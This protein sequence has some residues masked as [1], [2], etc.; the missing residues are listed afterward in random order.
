MKKIAIC[1]FLSSMLSLVSCDDFLTLEPETSLSPESYFKTAAELELWTNGFYSI[2]GD[3]EDEVRLCADDH[4]CTTLNSVQKGTRT[5]ATE[6]WSSSWDELRDINYFLEHVDNCTDEE[7]KN[8]FMGVAYFFRALFYFEKVR[9]YG[10]VPY[11]D[12]VISNTD[13]NALKKPRDSR[14]VVMKRVMDDFDKAYELL[15][16]T[17][18]VFHVTK[19]AAAAFKARAALFEGTYRK[20]HVISE[21]VE[22]ENVDGQ[23]VN[24]DW[25]LTQAV[26]ASQKVMDSK[27]F[28]VYKSNTTGL[29]AYREFFILED[30]N[31]DEMILAR[32]YEA[33]I[34]VRHGIQY[35][36]KNGLHC[37]T[38]RMVD[39]YLMSDGSRV[40]KQDNYDKMSYYEQ[41]QNRDPRMSQSLL[42]PG[43]HQY[44]TDKETVETLT[45]SMTGYSV[46]KFI[47]DTSFENDDTSTSDCSYFRYP[48]V[49]LI[50]AEAKAELGTITQSDIDKTVKII[51]DRVSM[52]NLDLD[53]ANAN[54]DEVLSSY[55]PHVGAGANRGAIL[56]IRRERT[57]ELFCEGQ[58]QWDMLRWGEGKF[59]TPLGNGKGF[60]GVYFPGVGEYDMNNDGNTDIYLYSGEKPD[61]E[62]GVIYYDIDSDITLSEGT[63]GYVLAYPKEDYVWDESRDYLWPIPENQIEITNGV[64]TQNPGY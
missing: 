10:D 32:R 21:G 11:Y 20:Y 23:T 49:L 7:A 1:L 50:Y 38:R 51:R 24:A 12:F 36:L 44:G 47:S 39:H 31:T 48:E 14:S 3:P 64:L 15:P 63:S 45:N 22:G 54:P 37:A 33:A 2:L 13:M 26:D 18:D 35:Q 59:L 55:Y 28:S 60:V 61:E 27:R 34:K 40:Q 53:W 56:E 5:A 41:F 19:Y 57:V 46:I 25:F 17:W 30:A 16:E 52:P 62:S 43:Y 9:Q 6:S 8:K 29:G 58:R 42:A 4:I